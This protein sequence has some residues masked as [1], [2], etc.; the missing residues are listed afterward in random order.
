MQ[1]AESAASFADPEYE[2]ARIVISN[3]EPP[4]RT[5][6]CRSRKVGWIK[7]LRSIGRWEYSSEINVDIRVGT[8]DQHG[9]SRMAEE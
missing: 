4:S 2:L 1:V 5:R 9:G 6:S 3:E 8:G 7:N